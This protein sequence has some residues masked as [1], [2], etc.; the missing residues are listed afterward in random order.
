[1]SRFLSIPQA[2]ERLNVSPRTLV[3]W[4]HRQII[5]GMFKEPGPSGR[6]RIPRKWV[7]ENTPEALHRKALE[8]HS[9]QG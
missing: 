5:P 3:N 8:Q 7:E 1:M 4:Y 2:A 6:Y 9:T